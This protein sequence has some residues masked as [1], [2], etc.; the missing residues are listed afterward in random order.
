MTSECTVRS[1]R[2]FHAWALAASALT[3]SLP[4][5]AHSGEASEWR[6]AQALPVQWSAP[7]NS[8]LTPEQLFFA[9]R[10]RELGTQ[11][12]A[13]CTALAREI[14]RLQRSHRKAAPDERT[15]TEAQLEQAQQ[16]LAA[17]RC[18]VDKPL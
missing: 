3:C 11:N 16:R 17:L 5:L 14:Q 8:G 2:S 6:M 7:L 10:K 1:A 15:H 12:Y 9:L 4:G 13:A 18:P